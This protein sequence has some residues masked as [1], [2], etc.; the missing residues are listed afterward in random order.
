[1]S[2][3]APLPPGEHNITYNEIEPGVWLVVCTCGYE[4]H[5]TSKTFAEGVAQR[6]YILVGKVKLK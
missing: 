5:A 1:M 4:Y 6:H 2:T 3:N